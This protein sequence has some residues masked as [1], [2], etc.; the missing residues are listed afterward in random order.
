MA[1]VVELGDAPVRDGQ[2]RVEDEV[3]ERVDVRFFGEVEAQAW[4]AAVA[5]LFEVLDDLAEEWK[6]RE[7]ADLLSDGSIGMSALDI[8]TKRGHATYFS[9][10]SI[11]Y[12]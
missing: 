6:G 12:S 7:D 8:W 4:F 11:P 5:G 1:A 2:A 9:D 3:D 10:G